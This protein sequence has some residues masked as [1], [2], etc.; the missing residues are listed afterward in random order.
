MRAAI[1]SLTLT[2]LAAAPAAAQVQPLETRTLQRTV[3]TVVVTG[4]SLGR[5]LLGTPISQLRA[6][7]CR[8]GFMIP[9]PY[10]VDEVDPEGVYCWTSGPKD[11][12]RRDNDGERLDSNDELV[13][14]SRDAG[15][16]ANPASFGMVPGHDAAQEI[17]LRDPLT[18]GKAW[19]YLFRFPR[20]APGRPTY[21][22]VDLEIKRKGD[23]GGLYIWTGESFQFNNG[24]SPS[25][26][27]RATWAG[28]SS[29]KRDFRN[30]VNILD[31]TQVRAVV[32]FMWVT[33]VRQSHEFRVKIGGYIDG[34]LRVVAEN[35]A[36]LYLALGIWVSAPASHVILWPNKV[37]MPTNASC[38]VNL[39]QSDESSYALA[40]D[41]SKDAPGLK[42]YNSHNREPVAIDGKT[43]PE[44]QAL[45]LSFPDWNVVYG[46]SGAMISKFV[47]P[48]FLRNRKGSKLLYIDDAAYE[49]PEKVDAIEFEPGAYGYHGYLMDMRGLRKG[50]YKG[51]YVVWYCAPPFAPGDEQAYLAEYDHPLEA[52]AVDEGDAKKK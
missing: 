2:L 33:V 48:D 34:P 5:T 25:N 38:P 17:E 52:T 39:D 11:R 23:D 24:R 1:T 50:V 16:R 20:A 21:D 3:D 37:S 7:A 32:S 51:D 9:I 47:I 35:L 27:V 10:Q 4:P 18:G 30:S 13:V 41:M 28:L 29:G 15:D 49:R 12:R 6:Y 42:F 26:A 40:V 8:A 31:S 45:D 14:L 44:E 46:P 36:Q 43:S 22:V 19:V